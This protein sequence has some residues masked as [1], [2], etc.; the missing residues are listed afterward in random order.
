MFFFLYSS[1]IV[2]SFSRNTNILVFRSMGC[3]LR[4]AFVAVRVYMVCMSPTV[5]FVIL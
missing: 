1:P 3:L 4:V 5:V 2:D